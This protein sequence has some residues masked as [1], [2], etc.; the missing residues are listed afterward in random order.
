[1]S[2]PRHSQRI[3]PSTTTPHHR[4][5]CSRTLCR[6]PWYGILLWDQRTASTC[7]SRPCSACRATRSHHR[8]STCSSPGSRHFRL[9]R[10]SS[11]DEHRNRR[12]YS[13]NPQFRLKLRRLSST[14]SSLTNLRNSS[15]NSRCL[16]GRHRCQCNHHQYLSRNPNLKSYQTLPWIQASKTA[17][18]NSCWMP[19]FSLSR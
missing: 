1:M 14:L 15:S 5:I 4:H 13:D 16:R 19:S 11:S 7:P 12:R 9:S 8:S 18:I 10:R 2:G 6:L 3:S 17:Q